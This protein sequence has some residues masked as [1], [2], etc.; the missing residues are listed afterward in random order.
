MIKKKKKF[1]AGEELRFHLEQKRVKMGV[2]A[3]VCIMV[4]K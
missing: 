3:L 4:R 2:V 1:P